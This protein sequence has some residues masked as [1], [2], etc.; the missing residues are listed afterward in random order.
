MASVRRPASP[1]NSGVLVAVVLGGPA[2]VTQPAIGLVVVPVE[3]ESA[4]EEDVSDVEDEVV[5]GEFLGALGSEMLK[6]CDMAALNVS[7]CL[8]IWKKKTS[9]LERFLEVP[10]FQVYSLMSLEFSVGMR[11]ERNTVYR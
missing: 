6:Y 1:P 2:F 3:E 8:K 9:P 11:L 7:P 5:V 4:V 10:T